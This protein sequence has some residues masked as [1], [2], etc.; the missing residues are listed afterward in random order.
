[1][2]VGPW[3]RWKFTT[4][5]PD[6]GAGALDKVKGHDPFMMHSWHRK[7]R[8]E[9]LQMEISLGYIRPSKPKPK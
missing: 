6:F 7:L 4:H 9:D 1:M 8:K 2:K 3:H 5:A